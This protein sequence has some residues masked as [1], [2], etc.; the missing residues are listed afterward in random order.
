MPYEIEFYESNL[1]QIIVGVQH[2]YIR[3]VRRVE[4]LERELKELKAKVTGETGYQG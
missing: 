1:H 4:E 3:L 2:R